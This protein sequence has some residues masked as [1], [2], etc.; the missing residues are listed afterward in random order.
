MSYKRTLFNQEKENCSS[1][2]TLLKYKMFL[3]VLNNMA[4]ITELELYCIWP[5]SKM[6]IFSNLTINW[7]IL[8]C[9]YFG[10]DYSTS[11]ASCL[12]MVLWMYYFS[13]LDNSK[14]LI[15]FLA[16]LIIV[17]SIALL[18]VLYKIYDLHKKRSW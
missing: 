17:T 14:A 4:K 5:Y 12:T 9:K 3:L 15:A 16:F 10:G 18:V 1:L 8:K 7:K 11:L 2:L 6:F 13:F